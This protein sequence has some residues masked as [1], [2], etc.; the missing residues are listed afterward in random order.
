MGADPR[1]GA[2]RPAAQSSIGAVREQRRAE[3]EN[4]RVDTRQAILESLEEILADTAL[5]EISVA[6]IV[7]HAGISRKGFYSYFESKFEAAGAVLEQVM[8][9]MYERWLPFVEPEDDQDPLGTL[10]RV[11]TTSFELWAAHSAIA[12][13]LHEYWQTVPEI[14]EQ[15]LAAIDRFT[16]GVAAAI[17]RARDAGVVPPGI[18]SRRAAAAGLWTGEQLMYVMRSGRSPEFPDLDAVYE[19]YVNTWAGLI[20]GPPQS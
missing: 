14:G 20:Y 18:D 12:R 19:A 8:N 2:T 3:A 9:R 17:D 15:W 11:L 16:E 5:H 10:Q 6:Q 13:A 1:V 4:P 7:E